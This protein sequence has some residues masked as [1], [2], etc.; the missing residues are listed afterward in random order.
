MS[1][2]GTRT[3]APPRRPK[4][5]RTLWVLTGSVLLT[6]AVLVALNLPRSPSVD[7]VVT[8]GPSA[9]ADA[10][11]GTSGRTWGRPNAPVRVIVFADFQCP[12]CKQFTTAREPQLAAEFVD[13]GKV[14]YEYHYMAFIGP[15][16][17]AAAEAAEC[18][19]EQ[20]GFWPY[21]DRLFARQGRENSGTY[22]ASVLKGVGREIA[23]A[24][25]NWDQSTFET[26]LDSGRTRMIVAADAAEAKAMG[27]TSTP[28]L[29]INGQPL[30]GVPSMESLR[31]AIT[32]ATRD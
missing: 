28:T 27:V 23:P 16:S 14:L 20:G 29:F 25:P 4:D 6:V 2:H 8:A 24:V 31:Q 12:F 1:Q 13:T 21:H 5:R 26:C 32:S 7:P 10:R 19:N 18:A 17:Q 9:T 15:E 11:T 3:I 22:S 30:I